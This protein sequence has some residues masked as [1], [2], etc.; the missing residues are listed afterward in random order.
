MAN[1]VTHG[2]WII[3]AVYCTLQLLWRSDTSSKI[4]VATVYGVALTLLFFISTFFHCMFYCN[5]NRQLK[6][7]LHRCDRAMIYIFIAGSYFPWLSL[8]T[9]VHSNLMTFLK[10]FVWTLAAMG[11][12]YQQVIKSFIYFPNCYKNIFE[13]NLNHPLLYNDNCHTLPIIFDLYISRN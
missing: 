12:A 1:V 8:S 11:I 10:W 13:S 9:P 3:P 6:D 2:I 7:F 5:R 4:F